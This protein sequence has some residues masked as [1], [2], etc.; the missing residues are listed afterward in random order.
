LRGISRTIVIDNLAPS[1]GIPIVEEPFDVAFAKSAD[2]AFA[3]GSTVEI[4][5]YVSLDGAPVGNGKVGPIT[6][7][8]VDAFSAFI[9]K[10]CG[11][12]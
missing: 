11:I 8:L 4:T 7:R 10:E 1:L 9:A 3:A 6:R 12:K 5:P 2:E